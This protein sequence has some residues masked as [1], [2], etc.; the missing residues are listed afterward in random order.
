MGFIDWSGKREDHYDDLVAFAKENEKYQ[1][2]NFGGQI[3]RKQYCDLFGV[4][5]F[6]KL[7]RDDVRKILV[8]EYAQLFTQYINMLDKS[9][10]EHTKPVIDY[11]KDLFMYKIVKYLHQA[12]IEN[13]KKIKA[14]DV[15]FDRVFK[16]NSDISAKALVTNISSKNEFS[17]YSQQYELKTGGYT[18]FWQW[19]GVLHS[20]SKSGL[21]FADLFLQFEIHL[22]YYLNLLV[23]TG[24]IGE[25]LAK[26]KGTCERVILSSINKRST[27]SECLSQMSNPFRREGIKIPDPIIITKEVEVPVPQTIELEKE[28]YVPKYYLDKSR[29]DELVKI[30]SIPSYIDCVRLLISC[31]LPEDIDNR[32]IKLKERLVVLNNSLDRFPDEREASERFI[33]Y[34]IPELIDIST[35]YIDYLNTGID[36][37]TIQN[38]GYDIIKSTDALISAIND[39][40]EEMYLYTAMEMKARAI[41]VENILGQDGFVNPAFRLVITDDSAK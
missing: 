3:K 25:R 27:I 1:K 10:I 36:E 5:E 17:Y 23:P 39:R 13:E 26:Q 37:S 14:C 15:L 7:N 31:N 28:V 11:F 21:D 9:S 24:H 12:V 40:L 4:P 32:Y 33:E 19:I 22:V 20:K 6:I 41:A 34:Y 2:D 16:F 29:I 8:V 30:A 18:P 35:V 38:A